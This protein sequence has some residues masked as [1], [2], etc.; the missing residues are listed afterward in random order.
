MVTILGSSISDLTPVS[1]VCPQFYN[2]KLD[3][4]MWF[5][6]NFSRALYFSPRSKD[7]YTFGYLTNGGISLPQ[8]GH[9]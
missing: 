6:W 7:P 4:I 1:H 3:I 9:H 8:V 5:L 2:F